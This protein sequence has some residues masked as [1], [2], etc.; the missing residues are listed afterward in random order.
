MSDWNFARVWDSI[1]AEAPERVAV[2]CG[3]TTRTYGDLARRAAGLAGTLERSGVR[4]G[5]KVA[6]DLL[7]RPEYL[8]T[9]YAALLLGA[10]PVNVNYRYGVEETRYLLDDADAAVV[11]TE[12][13]FAEVVAAAVAE[14][15]RTPV[16]LVLGPEYD[17]AVSASPLERVHTPS[18]D[19]L[20][21]LY[22]GGTT[23]MPKGVMWRTDDLYAALWQ[24]GR[25]GS[26]P[27]DPLVAV[28]AGKRAATTLPACPLMH[29]TGLFVT[30]SALSGG[31]TV[32]LIDEMGL[33]P[34]RIWDEVDARA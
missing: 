17:A 11:V 2:V 8:E 23:G 28:R 30:L 19:D 29:G 5:D 24:M 7:N 13:R 26:E 12:D 15:D 3:G 4:A 21:F 34:V 14:L 22:T 20:L 25:P 6:I 27:P 18:G 31:G 33:D 16:V 1:A 9:F 32:V 10:V